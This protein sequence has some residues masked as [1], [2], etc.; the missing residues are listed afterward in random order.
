MKRAQPDIA[1][2]N[3]LERRV[4]TDQ[5][6][7]VCRGADLRHVLV[8]NRH[9]LDRTAARAWTR[10]RGGDST[11]LEPTSRYAEAC[12]AFSASIASNAWAAASRATGIRNGEQLT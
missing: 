1:P 10:L 12:A 4:L 11:W 8:G 5:G 9:R 2:S 7:D 6:E 3:P